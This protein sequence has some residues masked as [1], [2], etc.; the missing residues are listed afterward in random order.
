MNRRDFLKAGGTLAVGFAFFG[1]AV[2]AQPRTLQSY[3]RIDSWLEILSDG[4]VRVF[5]GKLELGQG[6]R[7]AVAQMAAEELNL[8]IERVSVVLADTD[9][10]PNERYTAGSRSIEQSAQ[11]VRYAA[12]AARE[13]LVEMAARKWD[14]ASAEIEVLEGNV[15]SKDGARTISFGRLLEGRKLEHQIAGPVKLKPKQHY[16]YVGKPIHRRDIKQMVKGEPLYVQDLRFEGMLHARVVRPP[17]YGGKLLSIPEQLPSGLVKVVRDGSFLAVVSE[18]EWTAVK[19][20]EELGKRSRWESPPLPERTSDQGRQEVESRGEPEFTPHHQ[21]TYSKPY[22]MHASVGPSCAVAHFHNDRMT[23]WSHS[24]GVFPLRASVRAMLK[25]PAEKIRIIGTPGSG[26]YGHNGADDVAA[27]AALIARTLPGKHIRVQWSREDE[28][29]WEP[30]GS[31]MEMRLAAR[32]EEGKI[33]HWSHRVETDTHSTRPGGDAG[34]LLPS[35]YLAEPTPLTGEGF[36]G[37]G[38]RNAVPGYDIPNLG[39]E[40][41]FFEGPLR[42]SALRSLGAFANVFAIESFMDELAHKYDQ[43]PLEFRLRH[44]KDSRARAVIQRL[45]EMTSSYSDLGYG[46]ARYKGESS[47][48]AVAA[49]VEMEGERPRVRRMWGVIEAG[50][51]VNPDGLANQLEGGMIQAA[52][53]ALLEGVKWSKDGISGKDWDS[54]PILRMP[55]VPE[56]DVAILDRPD[57]PSLGAGE[58]AQGPS[59]AAVVNAVFAAGGG[60]RRALPLYRL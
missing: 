26:C 40:A 16:R 58:S 34:N 55:E 6:I 13:R 41:I 17:R 23:I 14:L 60:R 49:Q 48:C 44:L 25:M 1:G 52:S 37:G 53:W 57:L 39:V 10:T 3:P 36:R 56:L 22:I 18:S 38:Y 11:S 9:R 32:V 19:A 15:L 46:Y 33:T 8:D 51:V 43:E 31:A 45:A 47:Y 54:Y 4:S 30:Y 7:I 35:R 27:E 21:A 24:Q 59:G 42:V 12:A 20:A 29:G 28:H 2:Y 5:T 50:E